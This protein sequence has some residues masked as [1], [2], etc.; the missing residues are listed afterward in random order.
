MP[1]LDAGKS[2]DGAETRVLSKGHGDLVEGVGEGAHGV[3]LET[4]ALDCCI[5]DGQ[6]ACNLSRTSTVDDAVVAH[7]VS[8]DAKSVVQRSLGLVDD[9]LVGTAD[10]DSDGPGVGALLDDQHLVSCCSECELPD[11]T[12]PSELLGA[13][14]FE[15]GHDAA[16]G[17]DGDQLDLGAA[18]PSHSGQLVCEQEVVGFVVE[19]PLADDDVGARVLDLV[20]HLGELVGL[21][22]L[23]LLELLDRGD[24]EL[25]LG[26]GLRGLEGACEDGE[27]GVLD[28]GGH[29]GMREVLVYYDALDEQCVLER[30]SDLAI[31]LD[32]LEVDVLALE[33]CNG[34]N[35]IDGDVGKLVVRLG[36]D[37]G[38]QTCLCDLEQLL[39][40]LLGEVDLVTDLVEAGHGDLAGL[41]VAVCYPDGV[42]TLINEVCGLAEQCACQH[43]NT[44]CAVTNLVI[45]GLGQL[46]EQL[47]D[48]VRDLHLGK[49]GGAVVCYGDVAVGGDEDLVES[50]RALLESVPVPMPPYI[51]HV[52][53]YVRTSDVLTRLATV[54]AARMCDF[55]A[56]LPCC[57][58]FLP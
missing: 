20:D 10:K 42:D 6:R 17:C 30:S 7:E 38:A 45:L 52:C 55:T 1:R 24:V 43:Y 29:L 8:D 27:F 51:S 15:S 40:V 56:S 33:I 5:L 53:L 50:T 13:E 41:V 48:V 44:C 16:V 11:D 36:D 37:L 25:V 58:F 46:N 14:V 47:C 4:R 23:Q 22:V 57:L 26:L 54:C 49:N 32:Q 18:D 19:T 2:L 35:G 28:L 3:L 39:G 21:V 34:E 9:H 12:R 31:H